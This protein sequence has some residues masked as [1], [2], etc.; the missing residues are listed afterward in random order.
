MLN[1]RSHTCRGRLISGIPGR[2]RNV[3]R[4]KTNHVRGAAAVLLCIIAL[5]ACGRNGASSPALPA[6]TD[7]QSPANVKPAPMV[8]TKR[9][10]A[11]A[12]RIVRP[13][14]DFAGST[15]TQIPGSATQVAASYDGSLWVLSTNPAGADK[16]I[17]HYANGTWTN[18]PGLAMQLAV[19]PDYSLYVINAGG[20]TYHYAGG[21]WT[22][23]GGGASAIS[24]A[25][26]GSAYVVS[27]GGAGTIWKN[28]GGMWTSIGGSAMTIGANW[29]P[30]SYAVNGG[31]VGPYGLF[32]LN[33][34]GSLYYTT[35]NGQYLKFPGS[36]SALA[37]SLGGLYALGYAP[38][39]S[40]GKTIYYF[41]YTVG[42]WKTEPGSG[43]SMS[44]NFL[45]AYVVSPSGAIY[46]T[47]LQS[48]LGPLSASPAS[49]N[50]LTGGEQ[51]L[52]ADDG[53]GGYK[54]SGYNSSVISVATDPIFAPSQDVTGLAVGSTTITIT[55]A[56]GNTVAVPVTVTSSP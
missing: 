49:L 1:F 35:G 15:W 56:G 42:T 24:I 10:P 55:D 36:A 28:S 4:M 21:T 48:P 11:S 50:I 3:A 18:I 20:G 22:A 54:F 37:P 12:M 29:D 16:Y 26:D 30:N 40:N 52:Q 27:N 23:L 5:S 44:A 38:G 17:W 2:P 46:S 9:L 43:V 51:L 13:D 32:V 45:A 41:D 34:T 39:T 53:F 6:R 25:A 33:S 31:T 47:P 19:A 8:I 7:V 14:E